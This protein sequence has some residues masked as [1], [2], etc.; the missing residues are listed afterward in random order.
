MSDPANG[1]HLCP[2]KIVR[3]TRNTVPQG[4]F[5]HAE[6]PYLPFKIVA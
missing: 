4:P 5:R 6:L 1:A 3:G 2:S